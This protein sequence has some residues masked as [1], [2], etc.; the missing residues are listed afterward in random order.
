[1]E[2]SGK[3]EGRRKLLGIYLKS[4]SSTCVE[5]KTLRL[6][7]FGY[8]LAIGC[9]TRFDDIVLIIKRTISN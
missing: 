6:L 4:E 5:T 9:A 2:Q 1:M 3:N 8:C 7:S